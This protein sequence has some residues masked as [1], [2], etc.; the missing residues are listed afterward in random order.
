MAYL[1]NLL[2]PQSSPAEVE[3]R[4]CEAMEEDGYERLQRAVLFPYS[5][6]NDF[7]VFLLSNSTQVILVC[8]DS[9]NQSGNT[10]TNPVAIF[11]C[12]LVWQEGS[13]WGIKAGGRDTGSG[14]FNNRKAGYFKNWIEDRKLNW[15]V[16]RIPHFPNA[17]K[18]SRLRSCLQYGTTFTDR[19]I[20]EF[21]SRLGMPF[22]A[23]TFREIEDVWGGSIEAKQVGEWQVQLLA[24]TQKAAPVKK[25]RRTSPNYVPTIVLP[26]EE[27]VSRLRRVLTFCGMLVA[28]PLILLLVLLAIPLLLLVLLFYSPLVERIMAGKSRKIRNQF[29]EKLEDGSANQILLS[30]GKIFNT[31]HRCSVSV[32]PGIEAQ[33]KVFRLKP[34]PFPWYSLVFDFKLGEMWLHGTAYRPDFDRGWPGIP[35]NREQESQTEFTAGPY[36]GTKIF[37]QTRTQQ[38][39]WLHYDWFIKTPQAIYEFSLNGQNKAVSEDALSKVDELVRSFEL[40]ES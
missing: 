25:A 30:P 27:E 2:V 37:Y 21:C 34:D 3:R 29:L 36:A 13:Y 5:D 35:A 20:G 15:L 22:G 18:W 23:L 40:K 6:V 11:D 38:S 7:R 14:R 17:D 4:L 32:P 10:R 39:V 33:S 19:A 8:S 26:N 12:L 1:A 28:A 9:L 31:V 16:D 24:F